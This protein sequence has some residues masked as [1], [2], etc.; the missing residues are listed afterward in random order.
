MTF[1]DFHM[2][3][4]RIRQLFKEQDIK[5][6]ALQVNPMLNDTQ[7]KRMI[8]SRIK[9]FTKIL[10]LKRA[11]VPVIFADEACFTAG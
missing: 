2:T 4:Y 6:R 5:K 10:S 8:N 1:K 7:R 3:Y 9:A 11:G